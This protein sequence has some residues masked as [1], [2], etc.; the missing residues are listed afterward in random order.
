VP[1]YAWKA[2]SNRAAAS[3]ERNALV[4]FMSD[5]LCFARYDSDGTIISISAG[6]ANE[7]RIQN[8]IFDLSF[9]FKKRVH[10]IAV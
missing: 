8:I 1:E 10:P 7:N 2:L 4:L 5:L 9:H 3:T 6:N